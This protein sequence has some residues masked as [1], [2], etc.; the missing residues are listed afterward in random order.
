MMG[1]GAVRFLPF[2]TEPVV[3]R[4]LATRNG[5]EI[6]HLKLDW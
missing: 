3:V 4:S 2:T 5:Q 6:D 1:D